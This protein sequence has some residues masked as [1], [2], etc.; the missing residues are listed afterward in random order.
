M[1][2]P[3]KYEVTTLHYG[4]IQFVYSAEV[5]H[6]PKRWEYAEKFREKLN[7]LVVQHDVAENDGFCCQCEGYQIQGENK[8][9]V[10][11]AIKALAIYIGRF[12]CVEFVT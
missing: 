4:T 1:S 5:L 7:E 10:E 8:E 3:L 11:A 2:R 12:K 9:Q 6:S